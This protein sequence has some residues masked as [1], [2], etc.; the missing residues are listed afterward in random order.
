MSSEAVADRERLVR[1]SAAVATG[2]LLS[3]LT[4][5][6]RVAVLAYAV[7][8]ASL[9]DTYN[10]ANSTPNIVYELILGGV[11]SA[12]LVPLFV[13]NLENRD[14]RATAALFTVAMTVLTVLTVDRDGVRAADRPPLRAR[15]APGA[16][17]IAQLH[18]MTIFTLWF[19]P[20]MLFYGFTALATA[21]LNA[22]RRFVAAA[23]APVVNNVLVIGV[24]VVFAQ[25][26]AG[27]RGQWTD[28]RRI[29]GDVGKL[30]L[31]GAG[32]TAGIAAMALVL[33]PALR[34]ARVHLHPVFD[35][36]H[37]AVRKML[38]LVG[39]DDRLRRHESDRAAVRARAG[40]ERSHRQRLRVSLRVRVL[41]SAARA[42]RG[43][44][45][46]H[47]D[48]RAVAQRVPRRLLGIGLPVPRR[49]ALSPP[50]HDSRGDAV[51]R[52]R[53]THARGARARRIPAARRRG[54]RRH[55]AGALGRARVVLGVPLHA[56][57]L[58][59]AA[60]HVHAVLDQRDRERRSTSCSRSALF[61]SL[62]VQG[63]ALAWSGAY[64][65]A[66]VISV[67]VLRRRVPHP[68]DRAV[69]LSALR[70]VV[71][72]VALAIV[73]ASLAAAIG[74][75][76]ANRAL[77]ATAV[78]GLAGVRRV[79]R[80][81]RRA[82]HAGAGV[83]RS[84]CSGGERFL[85]T[86]DP[87]RV[88]MGRSRRI[89]TTRTRG[90]A[91][92]VR[93]VTDSACDLPPEM[94]EEL[95]IEVVPLTIRFG[96]REYV[97][98]KELTTDEFWRQL[99]SSAVLPETAAPSVG[100]FEETFRAP[101]RRR[102]R[103]H[104]VRQPLGASLGDDAVGAGRGQGARRTVPDRDHRLRA[105]RRWASASS[106][107]YAARR[108]SE[109]ADV[110]TIAREVNE[111]RDRQTLF[112]ALD[113]LEYLRKGGRIGG[114]Q[115]MLGSMLSIKPIITVERRRGRAGRARSAPARRPCASCSTGSPKARSSR[116]A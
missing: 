92:A 3:R 23:F 44:D 68:V 28:V 80:R 24:L 59:R 103:R 51:H 60:G 33:L 78:A 52:A 89:G 5:L 74:H 108:A 79:R 102:R 38:P 48:A 46:D 94:C 35:W 93:V 63:L 70:A 91:M 19:L 47:D 76:T 40:E 62:G 99:E 73:A 18:V 31:L 65:V 67:V 66:A 96:D 69:G 14:D 26:T 4:G 113:T 106:R 107:C 82:A 16:E 97:D 112:A 71:G 30:T 101:A 115:A 12:T 77:L 45:H 13:E 64:T 61:P 58:L 83:S 95:G 72:T 7:G 57:R 100:A 25:S 41:P 87:G 2:T 11:L 49:V 37:P 109:G 8:R 88:T 81:A 29:S 9:A 15:H 20:Q 10:L 39:V 50:A 54:H 43:V 105:P 6:L 55:L 75:P 21:L 86:S 27:S 84:E 56:A 85:P 104:R 36:R 32:T 98:R 114:A 110:A 53:A 17:R 111:R 1:S 42:A 116:S 34:R 22:H 90:G